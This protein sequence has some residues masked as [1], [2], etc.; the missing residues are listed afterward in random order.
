MEN[1][2][3][4]NEA[5]TRA[6]EILSEVKHANALVADGKEVACDRRLQGI[7]AR[8]L[9]FIE[10]LRLIPDNVNVAQETYEEQPVAPTE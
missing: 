9:N 10:F 5:L 4:R 3:V 8:I 6:G 1:V 7:R 2:N